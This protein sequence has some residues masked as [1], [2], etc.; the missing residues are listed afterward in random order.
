MPPLH[1]GIAFPRPPGRAVRGHDGRHPIASHAG[2][3]GSGTTI[4]DNPSWRRHKGACIHYRE[5]WTTHDEP[6]DDGCTLL[7]Q[8][9]CLMNTPPVS[10]D[11]QA[12]CMGSTHGCWRLKQGSTRRRDA[13]GAE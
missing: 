10:P 3:R 11:E 9:F 1:H 13:V 12:L 2:S 4:E 7:Y 6:G 5:R 8:I